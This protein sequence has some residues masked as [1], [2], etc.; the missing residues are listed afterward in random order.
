[1]ESIWGGTPTPSVG[2]GARKIRVEK[3][4]RKTCREVGSK[5][6]GESC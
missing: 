1:M 5:A 4:K 2:S 3:R 6:G